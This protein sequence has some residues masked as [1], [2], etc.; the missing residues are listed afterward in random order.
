MPP[1]RIGCVQYLNTLPLIEGLRTWRDAELVAAVPSRLIDLLLT[2]QVDV[3][4]CSVIDAARKRDPGADGLPVTLLPVGM[5]GSDGPTYTVRLFSSRPIAELESVA[6]DTDSHTS[7]ALLQ[8]LMHKLHA[9]RIR[10]V[11]FDARERVVLGSPPLRGGSSSDPSH[12]WPD[13][14][15]LIG[16]KVV[17]DAPP[18][19][20]Y[21][22]QL[23][24]GAAWKQLTG[25]PFVYA[26]W[27][28]RAGEEQMPAVRAASMMLDR[29]RRHNHTRLDWIVN[30]R[31]SEKH[32]PTDQAR[33]YLGEYL[34]YDVGEAER[35]SVAKFLRF[36]AELGLCST[37]E[38]RWADEAQVS[39]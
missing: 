8:V 11:D 20:R 27:M 4:L 29:A 1:V 5:I 26:T 7:I 2:Q 18:A 16:D 31:S 38:P 15:L 25:L 34:H 36:S 12:N 22:H 17:T 14:V 39:T 9:R 6:V 28:S 13:A 35:E 21:P 10:I 23:D 3:A 24:L 30:A 19:D 37:V 32:W 33:T